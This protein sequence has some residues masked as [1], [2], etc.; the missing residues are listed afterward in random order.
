MTI[1]LKLVGLEEMES[2]EVQEV[3][4][5]LEPTV[6]LSSSRSKITLAELKSKRREAMVVRVVK[7]AQAELAEKAAK[8]VMVMTANLADMAEMVAM[9]AVA[10]LVALVALEGT[11]EA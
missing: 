5:D 7:V 6:V 11:V 8:V 4:V 1:V 2:V 10:V 3:L 9:E